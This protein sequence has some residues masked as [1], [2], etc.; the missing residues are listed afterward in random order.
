[1]QKPLSVSALNAQIKALLEST[2]LH[3]RVEGEVSR[4]TYH[5]SGHLYFT[6]KDVNSAVSCVMFRGNNQKLAFR[7]EE[8]MHLVVWGAISVYAP[9]GN[10]Q[11]NCFGAEPSGSGA[12][13]LAYEQLKRE[14]EAKGYFESSRKKPLPHFPKR[15][16]LVTSGTGAALQDMKHIATKRWPLVTLIVIDT[17]VQGKEAAPSIVNSLKKADEVQADVIVLAR[18]GGSVEDLWAFNERIVAKAVFDAR[19]P[20][21]SA[22]GHEIDYV[23]T[24]FIADKRAPTPSAALELLLPDQDEIRISMDHLLDSLNQRVDEILNYQ[25]QQIEHLAKRLSHHSLDV[26]IGYKLEE[27]NSLKTAF[28]RTFLYKIER[29]KFD[30][31]ATKE[32]LERSTYQLIAKK[33]SNLVALKSSYEAK[34]SMLELKVG[35]AQLVFKDKPAQAHLLSLNDEIQIQTPKVVLGAKVTKKRML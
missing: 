14:L 5:A 32:R 19:L 3:V 18:G 16:A 4:A 29:F 34:S 6:L 2:F 28:E 12:L 11:I 21:V 9:R 20:V 13:A 24:D 33:E 30:L 8:G 35:F 10:Y 22:I 17:L 1:M 7:V 23:I 27:I 31:S 25:K 26:K 15:V